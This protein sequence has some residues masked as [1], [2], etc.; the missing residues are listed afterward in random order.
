MHHY[1]SDGKAHAKKISAKFVRCPDLKLKQAG[2][3]SASENDKKFE[4]QTFF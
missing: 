3:K 2:A 1:K 4:M